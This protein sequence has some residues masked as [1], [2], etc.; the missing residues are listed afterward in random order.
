[1]FL[2]SLQFTLCIFT[3]FSQFLSLGDYFLCK[4]QHTRI[5]LKSLGAMGPKKTQEET[6]VTSMDLLVFLVL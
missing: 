3:V 4:H 6:K 5:H 1:M 2:F